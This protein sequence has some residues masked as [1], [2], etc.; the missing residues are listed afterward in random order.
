KELDAAEVESSVIKGIQIKINGS[1]NFQTIEIDEELLKPEN[2]KRFE[3]DL[4]RSLNA[5]IKASQNLAAQKMKGA[6]P[7]FPGI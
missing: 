2:K 6:L 7:G 3:G 1:Q 4:L 5:A